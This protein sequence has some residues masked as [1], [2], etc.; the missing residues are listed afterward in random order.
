MIYSLS[1]SREILEYSL[2]TESLVDDINH[3]QAD[4]WNVIP[5]LF[6]RVYKQS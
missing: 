5:P 2:E 4:A 6:E 1:E 3:V